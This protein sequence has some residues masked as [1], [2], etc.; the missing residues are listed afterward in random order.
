M[1]C[2]R[3]EVRDAL[4]YGV[5]STFLAYLMI[6]LRSIARESFDEIFLFFL[7]ASKSLQFSFVYVCLNLLLDLSVA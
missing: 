1:P 7:V 6:G 5:E 4:F 2:L 3:I